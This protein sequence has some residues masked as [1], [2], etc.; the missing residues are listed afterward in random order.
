[1]K[2]DS[3]FVFFKQLIVN[4]SLKYKIQLISLACLSLLSASSLLI[5][6]LLLRDYNNL[7]SQSV[8]SS[9]SYANE[10]ITET[11]ENVQDLSYTIL[12]DSGIQRK[13]ADLKSI[14]SPT[15][16][17]A[18]YTELNSLLQSYYLD[19]RKHH[20]SWINVYTDD[21]IFQTNYK[22]TESFSD[23]AI[24]SILARATDQKG[25]A[26]WITDYTQDNSL[27]LAREIKRYENLR[28]DTLGVMVIC[29]DLEDLL[30]SQSIVSEYESVHY[31]LTDADN[32]ILYNTSSI[33]KP[34]LSS[35]YIPTGDEYRVIKLDHHWYLAV[36]G[37]LYEK[38]NWN[39]LCLVSYDK[40]HDTLRDSNL[41]GLFLILISLLIIIL[42]SSHFINA[43]TIHFDYL[44]LKMKYLGQ[45][46]QSI[47]NYNYDCPYDYSNRDDEVGLLHKQFDHMTSQIS[48]LIT[49][50]YTYEL[51]L[52]ETQLKALEMQINPH[53]LYNTLETINWRAKSIGETQI[54]TMAES[55]GKLFRSVLR[56]P[57]ETFTLKQELELVQY[58]L[59]IQK[60]RFDTRLLYE[61]QVPE[62]LFE[63]MVPKLVIQ[64]LVENSIYHALDKLIEECQILICASFEEPNLFIYVKNSGSK[65]ETNLLQK[66]RD[67]TIIPRGIGIG[68][69]NIQQRIQLQFGEQYGLSLYNED[70][71]AVAQICLPC[72]KKGKE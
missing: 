36:T 70:Q 49:T 60:C 47:I 53:F 18:S 8:K 39:Y 25:T 5:I 58:Y 41:L 48:Q 15:Q 45:S 17:S 65:F 55:L 14:T 62:S 54:S 66:L 27:L 57:K 16:K 38:E 22:K 46:E 37:T 23:Q 67:K 26:V 4:L 35:K 51:L 6:Q 32:Q 69:L 71:W 31:L 40:I 10:D 63:L 30:V 21:L 7:L 34:E 3:V 68:L 72:Q 61:I 52:K 2:F 19:Y 50:K 42:L 43:L 33:S 44:I 29:I 64:P 12:S 9:L 28:L 20:I 56:D 59:N 1:M 13:L 11:L 24:T